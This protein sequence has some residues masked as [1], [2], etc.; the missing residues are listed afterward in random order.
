LQDR[1]RG[2]LHVEVRD[3]G[4]GIAPEQQALIF[5]PFHQA[6]G[7]TSRRYGGTGLGLAICTRLLD[8]MG[9]H[10][11]VESQPG[12]GSAFHFTANFT[13]A[14]GAAP[15]PPAPSAPP[16]SPPA[17]MHILLV[18]DNAVNQKLA[19]RL[20]ENAGNR[21]TCANN[22]QEA[23]ALFDAGPF[24]LVLMDIQMPVMDGIEATV[25]WR[26]REQPSPRRHTPILALT[27]N[28]MTGDRERCLQAG[29]DGYITKPIRPPEMFQQIREAT[30]GHGC[31]QR[32]TDENNASNPCSSV[33]IRG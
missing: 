9:G 1:S 3:T 33:S 22:G 17:G 31:I 4:I 16:D 8:M 11:W 20:L 27:A 7:S 5:Q 19:R 30:I 2:E 29:M 24:D 10:I 15:A 32:H 21:V 26:R 18:E 6:D 14:A 23:L 25:E 12:Q 13:V 28:A